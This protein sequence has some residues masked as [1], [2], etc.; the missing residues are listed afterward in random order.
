VG[1]D[2][3][4]ILD[5]FLDGVIVVDEW[6][7]VRQLNDAACRI[8]E[9]SADAVVGHPVD[10]V[11]GSEHPLG[12]HARH[13]IQ[14]ARASV[15]SEVRVER[16]LEEDVLVDV[17]AA[18]IFDDLG[19]VD[20][21]LLV[22]RDRT[23]R[24]AIEADAAE[25]ERLDW[26][27]RIALGIAH[28]VKNPLGGI[29]G[30]GELLAGRATDAKTRRTAELIV[31]EV[32][33]I[34]KLV[35]DFMVLA[36]DEEPRTGAVNVHLVLDEVLDLLSHDSVAAPS[37]GERFFDPSI[38]ELPGDRE[39]LAQIFHN[40]ARNAFEAMLPE[41]GTLEVTTRMSLSRRLSTAQGAP[42]A[43]VAIG[44]RDTGP[45]IPA[46]VMGKVATPFFTTR[47]DGTG[48]GLPLADHWVTRHD[49]RL[50]IQSRPGS[51]VSVTVYLP[52][53]RPE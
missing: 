1:R 46:E 50:R 12:R 49:G 5:A 16:R 36:R 42:V 32:D 40:I 20:G 33:R 17:S 53:R 52:L 7:I 48:L 2:L 35:E 51:G 19:N 41:G 39:R 34:A 4:H 13:A 45:G 14:T 18:P 27:A 47:K 28:E 8:L 23:L 3:G 6:G 24:S 31:R 29:R 9:A 44:F 15:E 25:R 21:A 10:D 26:S 11:H 30:A 38:P 37:R 22:L 43:T